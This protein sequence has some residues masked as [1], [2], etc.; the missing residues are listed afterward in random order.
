MGRLAGH[1]RAL[2][3]TVFG[4]V[5]GSWAR[6]LGPVDRLRLVVFPR[7]LGNNGQGPLFSGYRDTHFK[8]GRTTVIDSASLLLYYQPD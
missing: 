1:D 2:F 7:I 5:I 4:L 6:T 8:L 3:T